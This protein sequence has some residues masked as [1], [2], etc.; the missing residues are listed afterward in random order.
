M[1]SLLSRASFYA[2]VLFLLSIFTYS[3]IILFIA[4]SF[5]S[6]MNLLSLVL[7]EPSSIFYLN[8]I[9]PIETV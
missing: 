5:S 9:L 2:K 7:L 4:L 8:P 6:T 1:S 3:K